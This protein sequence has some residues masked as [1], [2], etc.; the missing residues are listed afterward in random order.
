MA[1]DCLLDN[2]DNEQFIQQLFCIENTS[3]LLRYSNFQG[4]HF[5]SCLLLY[6]ALLIYSHTTLGLYGG[7]TCLF[8]SADQLINWKKLWALMSPTTPSLRLGSRTNNWKEGQ[9]EIQLNCKRQKC[10]VCDSTLDTTYYSPAQVGSLIRWWSTWGSWGHPT[11]WIQTAR[12]HCH[13]GMATDQSASRRRAHR[14]TT[15]LLRRC[16]SVQPGSMKE[17]TSGVA[18]RASAIFVKATRR[19]TNIY[20]YNNTN[21]RRVRFGI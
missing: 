9:E 12:P 11:G 18:S 17:E 15:S 1:S 20:L 6:C 16:T 13:R 5:V 8:S 14:M 3:L 19:H 4:A 10:R 7:S 2:S 21:K